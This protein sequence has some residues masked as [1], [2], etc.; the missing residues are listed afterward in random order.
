MTH[1]QIK[2]LRPPRMLFRHSGLSGVQSN[3]RCWHR[4]HVCYMCFMYV[5]TLVGI[6]LIS[7]EQR[8]W[9]IKAFSLSDIKILRAW[10]RIP[11][12]A[13][14]HAYTHMIIMIL[15]II[16]WIIMIMIMLLIMSHCI[17]LFFFALTWHCWGAVECITWPS[18]PVLCVS[19]VRWISPLL[20]KSYSGS[21]IMA[22]CGQVPNNTV[23]CCPHL[24]SSK[25]LCVYAFIVFKE[26]SAVPVAKN[27]G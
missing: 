26:T 20:Y 16:V 27:E 13:G 25:P 10:I 19:A 1:T 14:K 21:T 24:E 17:V 4:P 7:A 11:P 12:S 2:C 18:G 23:I 8:L 22:S 9:F 5:V 6:S 15:M 3:V